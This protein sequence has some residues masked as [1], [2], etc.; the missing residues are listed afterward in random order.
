MTL[1]KKKLSEVEGDANN[2]TSQ[3]LLSFLCPE[4]AHAVPSFSDSRSKSTTTV[5]SRM[6]LKNRSQ[7][8]MFMFFLFLVDDDVERATRWIHISREYFLPHRTHRAITNTCALSQSV[9][10]ASC[11]NKSYFVV[12]LQGYSNVF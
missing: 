6:L 12:R 4:R 7:E 5:E 3:V 1:A 10:H 8:P 2:N 11:G 9:Q